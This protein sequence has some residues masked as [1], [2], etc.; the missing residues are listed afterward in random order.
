MSLLG[1]GEFFDWFVYAGVAE[2]DRED[3]PDWIDH[4]EKDSVDGF[5]E[6]EDDEEF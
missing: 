5:P 6:E 1:S 3:N 2:E 4:R